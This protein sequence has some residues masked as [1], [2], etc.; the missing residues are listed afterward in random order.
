MSKESFVLALSWIIT[1]GLLLFFVS[2]TKI[3]HAWLIFLFKQF[4]TWIFGLLV[5]EF[6]LIEYPVRIFEHASKTSFSFEYFVYPAI[7]VIFNLHYPEKKN[8]RRQLM[9]YSYYCTAI[10]VIEVLIE[11]NTDLIA[12]IHWSWSLTWITLFIT[13]FA[14]QEFYIWFFKPKN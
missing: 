9:H 12:Y 5:V 2:K 7:C 14:S 1:S 3:R 10:T 8:W 11:K 4:I 6:G 13:F